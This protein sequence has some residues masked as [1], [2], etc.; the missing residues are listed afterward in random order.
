[1]QQLYRV[2]TKMTNDILRFLSFFYSLT[3]PAEPL[4]LFPLGVL[5][6]LGA[7]HFTPFPA[8]VVS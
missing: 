1:M 3:E 2:F 7:K 6:G 5:G 8:K 4:S